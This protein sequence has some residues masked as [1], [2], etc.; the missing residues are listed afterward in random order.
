MGNP[1]ESNE[2][3]HIEIVSLVF[4]NA[5]LPRVCCYV[6]VTSVDLKIL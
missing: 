4:T 5:L 1:Q 2:C 3:L 6:I